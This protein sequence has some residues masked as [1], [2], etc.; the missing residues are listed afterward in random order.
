MFS[1][2]FF[3]LAPPC[4]GE[5]GCFNPIN[6]IPVPFVH[7]NQTP[8][9][10]YVMAYRDHSTKGASQV[11]ACDRGSRQAHCRRSGNVV[12]TDSSSHPPLPWPRLERSCRTFEMGPVS[13]NYVTTLQTTLGRKDQSVLIGLSI[14]A[15]QGFLTGFS[16]GRVLNE[17][18]KVSG[19]PWRNCPSSRHGKA[20]LRQTKTGNKEGPLFGCPR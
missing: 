8:S 15:S 13:R 2:R 11:R 16:A 6:G 18:P 4:G 14:L 12:Q 19:Q 5:P 9:A 17:G 10:D 3:R 7:L 20:S 1:L